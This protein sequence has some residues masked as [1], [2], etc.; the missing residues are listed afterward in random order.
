MVFLKD[1]FVGMSE[2]KTLL[3][4]SAADVALELLRVRLGAS[5]N[6]EELTV[7]VVSESPTHAMVTLVPRTFPGT[8][9]SIF[10]QITSFR[11]KKLSLKDYWPANMTYPRSGPYPATQF[12]TLLERAYGI[13]LTP[14][15][16]VVSNGNIVTHQITAI[17]FEIEIAATSA[18]FV[19]GERLR[20]KNTSGL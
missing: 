9:I 16:V 6:A 10:K 5:L 17:D 13:V 19:S 12:L 7:S 20:I 14:E 3:N 15:D 4:S 8:R 11:L 2:S 18:R 1:R